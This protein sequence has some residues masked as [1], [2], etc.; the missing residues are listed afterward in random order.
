[1]QLLSA[2]SKT[3]IDVCWSLPTATGA[4]DENTHTLHAEYYYSRMVLDKMNN[5]EDND[6]EKRQQQNK[7]KETFNHTSHR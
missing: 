7:K 2:V 3:V 1:M 5:S 4:A 6:K